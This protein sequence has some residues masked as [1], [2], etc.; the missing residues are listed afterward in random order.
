[1]LT[2]IF[3]SLDKELM[4]VLTWIDKQINHWQDDSWMNK[5]RGGGGGRIATTRGVVI[6]VI[7]KL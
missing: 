2:M 1:M 6:N 7:I 4:K 5:F 3:W